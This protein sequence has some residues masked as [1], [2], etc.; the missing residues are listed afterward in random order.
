[1]FPECP[2]N[3][4]LFGQWPKAEISK[5]AITGDSYMDILQEKYQMLLSQM[6]IT[7]KTPVPP[8]KEPEMSENE[9]EFLRY[10]DIEELVKMAHVDP[11]H[12]DEA[13]EFLG[14]L[15]DA[16]VRMI[17]AIIERNPDTWHSL[18]PHRFPEMEIYDSVTGIMEDEELEE[19]N[20][21]LGG[22]PGLIAEVARANANLFA[23]LEILVCRETSWKNKVTVP[24]HFVAYS[25]GKAQV[26]YESWIPFE[27]VSKE[28]GT[29]KKPIRFVDV[30]NEFDEPENF[31]ITNLVAK[32]YGE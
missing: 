9:L 1:M 31:R 19:L 16:F 27:L 7:Y 18:P 32:V 29:M 4:N 30:V 28:I 20:V 15:K 26:P 25:H 5:P 12:W 8:V 17:N 2:Q 14:E 11:L 22:N 23:G 21:A 10:I 13:G 3:V 24:D 6:K